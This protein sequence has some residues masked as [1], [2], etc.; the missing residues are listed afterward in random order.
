MLAFHYV[1]LP[2]PLIAPVLVSVNPSGSCVSVFHLLA[3]LLPCLQNL[4]R[5]RMCPTHPYLSRTLQGA[6]YTADAPRRHTRENTGT[7]LEGQGIR[8]TNLGIRKAHREKSLQIHTRIKQ[9]LTS[10]FKFSPC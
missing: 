5:M 9:A 2:S 3:S 1:P 8:A 6:W 4:W 10:S 7:A